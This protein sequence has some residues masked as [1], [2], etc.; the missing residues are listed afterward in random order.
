MAKTKK[1][2]YISFEIKIGSQKYV[3]SGPLLSLE[4]YY[5]INRIPTATIVFKD[6]DPSKQ[7]FELSSE[8]YMN[9]GE[10]VEISLG[11]KG[12][13]KPVFKGVIIRHSIRASKAVGTYLKIE[14]KH[15][16][17]NMTVGKS[18]RYFE[19]QD[20]KKILQSLF[21]ENN[22]NSVNLSGTYIKKD[23]YLQYNTNDWDL[24]LSRAA[25]NSKV[26]SYDLDKVIVEDPK[27]SG[28]SKDIFEFGKDLFDYDAEVN[29]EFQM[30]KVEAFS[31][32]SK[33]QK[34]IKGTN[35]SSSI[36]QLENSG[37]KHSDLKTVI[38]RK[39][40]ELY[41][42]GELTKSEL[43]GWTKSKNVQSSLNKIIGSFKVKGENGLKL[44]DVIELKGLGAKFSGKILVTGIRN[45]YTKEGWFT[46]IQFGYSHRILGGSKSTDEY[47]S[48]VG[49]TV[50]N[51]GLQIGKVLKIDGDPDNRIQ[52]SLPVAGE[53]IKVWARMAAEDAGNKRGFVF[54]PEKGDEVVV[55]FLNDDPNFPIIL[56]SL[57]SKKN[58][59]VFKPD[60]KNPEKGIITKSDI[61]IV[62]NDKDKQVEIKTPGGNSISLDDKKKSILLK[63]QNNHI[64]KLDKKG[65]TLVSKGDITLNA[66]KNIN[67]KGKGKVVIDGMNVTAK[68]KTKF[69]AQ[70]GAGVDIK[71][72]AIA[73]IKG[74]LV[75]IN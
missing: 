11:Y 43:D 37:V 34:A 36:K 26:I 40:Y 72:S 27:I 6:G 22:V 55:G 20:D 24:A 63:D 48:V 12:S 16:V 31:W 42:N 9:P 59:P 45:D 28:A 47:G 17:F 64:V 75:K 53:K 69:M 54:W 7:D 52:I 51:R 74:S 33:T 67:I 49:E 60:P 39:S 29:A 13:N 41:H 56:G 61:R 14:C 21:S 58:A 25:F 46:D 18:I 2:G 50:A 30:S 3:S 4:T 15:P 1:D 71:S 65:I 66:T 70:G 19:K 73:S 10:K 44:G 68:A 38:P 32:D 8:K 35:T 23:S 62:F 5:E 57:Y